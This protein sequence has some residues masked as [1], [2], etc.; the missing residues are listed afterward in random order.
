LAHQV[1]RLESGEELSDAEFIQVR[2]HLQTQRTAWEN[3][4]IHANE[5]IHLE[6][7]EFERGLRTLL[8]SDR[9]IR[10]PACRVGRSGRRSGRDGHVEGAHV[11]TRT[12]VRAFG[13]GRRAA[14]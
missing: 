5:R 3:A 8:Q 14:A 13:L 10:N 6:P 11:T 1:H 4:Y 2:A 7:H 9:A 12:C